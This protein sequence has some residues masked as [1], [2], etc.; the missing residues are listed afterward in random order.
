[1]QTVAAAVT[2]AAPEQR[3]V[4]GIMGTASGTADLSRLLLLHAVA[5]TSLQSEGK[6]TA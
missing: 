1:M 4:S 5:F 2:P 6:Q 3:S